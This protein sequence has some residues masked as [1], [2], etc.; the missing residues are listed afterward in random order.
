M[1]AGALHLFLFL[2][3]PFTN[4]SHSLGLVC[5]FRNEDRNMANEHGEYG[6]PPW[7]ETVAMMRT[8]VDRDLGRAADQQHGQ[9]GQGRGVVEK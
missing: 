1:A 3:T 4:F 5:L 6:G 8:A 2:I 9:E 7:T